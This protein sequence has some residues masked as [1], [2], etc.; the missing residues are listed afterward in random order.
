M[1]RAMPYTL[2]WGTVYIGET[3][4]VAESAVSKDTLAICPS[5]AG[6]LDMVTDRSIFFFSFFLSYQGTPNNATTA[7]TPSS[8][9]PPISPPNDTESALRLLLASLL[10]SVLPSNL[11]NA[12]TTRPVCLP[13]FSSTPLA[14]N[15]ARGLGHRGVV[16]R[17]FFSSL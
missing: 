4:M 9:S 3:T 7:M 15:I 6:I 8:V 16:R 12:R 11:P 10:L 14:R 1:T 13:S 2:G 17:V 5:M